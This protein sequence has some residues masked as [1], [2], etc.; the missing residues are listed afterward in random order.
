MSS[1]QQSWRV[2]TKRT[3]H[4]CWW[5]GAHWH[6]WWQT[7]TLNIWYWFLDQLTFFSQVFWF[8]PPPRPMVG[9]HICRNKV[10]TV[11]NPELSKVLPFK[12]R[13]RSENSHAYVMFPWRP[14]RS[15]VWNGLNWLHLLLYNV[16]PC[17]PC[18]R[19]SLSLS[20]FFSGAQLAHTNSTLYAR[21]GPLW[22]S[23]LR[24]LWPSVPWQVV[25]ELSW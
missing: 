10:P 25:Y 9:Y 21:I 12:A 8:V 19:F 16:W 15:R 7:V 22:L 6:Q 1:E 4:W 24:W 14:N 11:K 20:L 23:R 2:L 13:S 18:L 17:I 5:V 3:C